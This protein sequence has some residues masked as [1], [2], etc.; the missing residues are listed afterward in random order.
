MNYG[1]LICSFFLKKKYTGDDKKIFLNNS[2]K[3]EEGDHTKTYNNI[4]DM[5]REFCELRKDSD[6]DID[7]MKLY[8]IDEKTIKE[9]NEEK[10]NALSFV[11]R[12][13][14]YGFESYLTDRK[15][16]KVK[17]Q[18]KKD[19]ADV[20]NFKCV[21]YLLKDIA[22]IKITKG[23]IVFQSIGNYGVKMITVQYLQKYFSE[24]NLMFETGSVSPKMFLD[25][26]IEKGNIDKLT[27][28][29]NK[30]SKNPAD[31]L[32]ISTGKEITTYVKPE[33]KK[34]AIE[35]LKSCFDNSENDLYEILGNNIDD[36]KISFDLNGKS[37]TVR[38]ATL[39]KLSIVEVIPKNIRTD[40]KVVEHMLNTAN[41][42]ASEMICY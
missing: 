5:F 22:D 32:L 1:M 33:L 10:Y 25:K 7:L 23:I 12:S 18:R 35:K 3:I 38:L 16:H 11:V 28:I 36:I 26:L 19:D 40:T 39:E 42:Y 27:L 24:L 2:I 4:L 6:D 21:V 37:R 15:T 29:R 30:I 20:K 17:Y 31:K 9:Y 41:E 13:G 8:S 34:G 14:S